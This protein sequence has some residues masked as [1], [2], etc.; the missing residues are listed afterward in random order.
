MFGIINYEMFFTSCIILSLIPGS[1]TV[2]ILTQS[3]SNNKKIGM[4]SALGISSGIIVH[5]TL[6][7]LGLSAILKSSPIAF[8]GVKFL[9][10]GYLI[11]LGI[12]SILT[13]ESLLL[14]EGPV[15]KS[16]L[17]KAYFQGLITNVLNPKIAL[18]FLAFLPQFINTE[19]DYYTT[20]A[21]VLLGLTYFFT[22]TIWSIILS[23]F[24][25]TASLFL[26]K[27]QGFSKMIN[28]ICGSIFI[29][30]GVNILLAKL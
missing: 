23:M 27:K 4:I 19:S 24:A 6:V 9:G 16:N 8:Q 10:A 17:K 28:K 25:S 13:K 5:T 22:A 21:F 30:L 7:T 11:Y 3:I 29:L 1:D 12:K 14:Q 18:F 26:K 20:F 2:F 15:S